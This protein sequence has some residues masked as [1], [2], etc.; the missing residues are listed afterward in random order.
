MLDALRALMDAG[1]AGATLKLYSGTQPANA[2]TGLS[3]NTLLA[4]LTFADPAA[5]AAAGG[6]L[7]FDAITEDSSADASATATWARIQDSDGEPIFDGDVNTA[8]AMIVLNTTTIVAGGPVSISSFTIS[9]PS[10]IT[11]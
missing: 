3:G 8:N 10:S 11:F 4:T 6:V 9:I 7:T 5:G 1:S 2:D